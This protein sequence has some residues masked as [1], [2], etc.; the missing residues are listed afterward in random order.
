MCPIPRIGKGNL[1]GRWSPYRV[2]SAMWHDVSDEPPYLAHGHVSALPLPPAPTL[3][4]LA[5]PNAGS[6]SSEP[7][8]IN[9]H[10]CS[11][12]QLRKVAHRGRIY[13]FAML[14]T[15]LFCCR[16]DWSSSPLRSAA[17]GSSPPV[18]CQRRLISH[19]DNVFLGLSSARNGRNSTSRLR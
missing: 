14:L 9:S 4:A 19:C 16:T 3:P 1:F 13:T 7:L 5:L 17:S 10:E 8:A 18:F 11:E 15:F 2:P 12:L 6:L